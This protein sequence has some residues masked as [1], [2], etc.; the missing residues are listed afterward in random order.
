MY[1][2]YDRLDL[3]DPNTSIP[4]LLSICATAIAVCNSIVLYRAHKKVTAVKKAIP[5]TFKTMLGIKDD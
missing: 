3:S 4:L 1:N 5:A 2:Y